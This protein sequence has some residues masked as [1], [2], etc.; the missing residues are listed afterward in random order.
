MRVRL[1][2]IPLEAVTLGF[3][4]AGYTND[5]ITEL[6]EMRLTHTIILPSH[7]ITVSPI[8]AGDPCLVLWNLVG[9]VGYE[10]LSKNE[11]PSHCHDSA[12]REPPNRASLG[13][14]Y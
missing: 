13:A 3:T 14:K 10:P 9:C 12:E 6:S 7:S 11:Y 8:R 2:D 4:R 5:V 1:A